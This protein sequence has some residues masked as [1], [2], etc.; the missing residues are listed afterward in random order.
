[1]SSTIGKIRKNVI[2]GRRLKEYTLYGSLVGSII[3][4]IGKLVGKGEDEMISD[5]AR[6]SK[7]GEFFKCK[8]I[9]AA[10]DYI[11]KDFNLPEEYKKY[12]VLCYDEGNKYTPIVTLV[13]DE[14][15]VQ[16]LDRSGTYL[17]ILA[18]DDFEMEYVFES[19]SE[20]EN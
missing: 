17:G 15:Y 13:D 5:F 9:K 12:I 3:V 8:N 1:M 20:S 4:T 10:V 11:A 14:G 16:P 18:Q 6:L 19:D 2:A 7:D